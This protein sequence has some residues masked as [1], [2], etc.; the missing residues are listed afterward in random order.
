[1][2]LQPRSTETEGRKV[3]VIVHVEIG[4]DVGSQDQAEE[5]CHTLDL[6]LETQLGAFPNGEI[7]GANVSHFTI[8]TEQEIDEKGWSE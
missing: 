6:G 2:A 3:I 1:M 5:A 4:I 8:A 7:V